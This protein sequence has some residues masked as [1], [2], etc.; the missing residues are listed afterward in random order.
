MEGVAETT[1]GGGLMQ[2]IQIVIAMTPDG[3]VSVNGPLENKVLMLGLLEI[4]KDLAL[5]HK[6]EEAPRVIRPMV[7][8]TLTGRG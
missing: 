3:Q 8:P 1:E 2:P 7:A 4:A 6:Q 5:K